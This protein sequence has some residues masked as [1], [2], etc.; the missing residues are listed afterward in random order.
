MINRRQLSVRLSG[1]GAGTIWAVFG[2]LVL[3]KAVLL[4][5]FGPIMTPDSPG[6]SGAAQTILV[7]SSWLHDAGMK[8]SVMPPFAFRIIGYPLFLAG[9]MTMAGSAWAVAAVCIQSAFSLFVSWKALRLGEELGLSR[10]WSLAAVFLYA[11]SLQL[12]LDQCI[13]TDSLNASCVI[14]ATVL[15]VRGTRAGLPLSLPAAFG[16]GLML[17]IAFLMREIMQ[18]MIFLFVIFLIVRLVCAQK[19]LRTRTF[20]AV[21]IV[22]AVPFA[23]MEGYRQWNV[24]RT[25]ERFITTGGQTAMLQ[26]LARVA[27]RHP[28]ILTEDTPLD[29]TL[30]SQLKYYT[31]A[32]ILKTDAELFK[33]GYTSLDISRMATA[34]YI[35]AWRE[36]PLQMLVLFRIISEAQVK[37][38]ART[39]SSICE[40]AEWSGGG[41]QCDDYRDLYRAALKTPM[42]MS[43]G[44]VTMFLAT[45]LQNLLSIIIFGAF[46]LG[47][48]VAVIAAGFRKIPPLALPQRALIAAFWLVYIGWCCGYFL[49]HFET[50]YVA[51]VVPLSVFGGLFIIQRTRAMRL[52][53]ASNGAGNGAA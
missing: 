3:L 28:G 47:T 2:A 5:V 53:G 30:K 38:A 22:L 6:Y 23:T 9:V 33:Q 50:R 46:L 16:A 31:F 34:R 27:E 10:G 37:I 32:E 43:A 40:V 19:G 45:S 21:L 17:A 18:A 7:T 44:Q 1:S 8:A 29:R 14:L 51:P 41:P 20:A 24:H 13:L 42:Q 52:Q 25:G 49:I 4:I 39:V 12:L 48:P 15:L 36:H 11:T 26:A 35:E